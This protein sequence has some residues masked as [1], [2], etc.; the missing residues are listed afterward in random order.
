VQ[1]DS[2]IIKYVNSGAKIKNYIIK[3]Q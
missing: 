3:S 2:I 1:F